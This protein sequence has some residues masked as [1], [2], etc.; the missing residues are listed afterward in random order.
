MVHVNCQMCATSNNT[1][2]KLLEC[3]LVK[4][5][6]TIQTVRGRLAY[7]DRQV[8]D[9]IH[10]CDVEMSTDDILKM[11]VK[12]PTEGGTQT[13]IQLMTFT[14]NISSS[15]TIISST[16][17]SD[18]L[19]AYFDNGAFNAVTA[20]N[21]VNIFTLTNTNVDNSGIAFNTNTGLITLTGRCVINFHVIA[22]D[23][24]GINSYINTRIRIDGNTKMK[25]TSRAFNSNGYVNLSISYVCNSGTQLDCQIYGASGNNKTILCSYNVSIY[26]I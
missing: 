21:W 2:R 11:L 14:M 25:Q 15:P 6:N 9:F 24:S 10:M 18:Y 20:T 23:N 3:K 17:S 12:S 5:G 16:V 19:N 26:N 8:T 22:G 7:N 1:T 4:N 13:Q